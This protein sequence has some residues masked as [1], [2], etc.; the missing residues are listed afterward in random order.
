MVVR[1][2]TSLV[3]LGNQVED[4]GLSTLN[5]VHIILEAQLVGIPIMPEKC[6]LEDWQL[7]KRFSI[8]Y[9][10]IARVRSLECLNKMWYSLRKKQHD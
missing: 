9:R 10:T 1:H 3:A 7:A 4:E 8:A 6:M 5:K 2:E